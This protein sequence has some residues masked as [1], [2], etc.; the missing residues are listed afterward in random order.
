MWFN[1]SQG[2][3]IMK[4]NIETLKT[5]RDI[6]MNIKLLYEIYNYNIRLKAIE[7]LDYQINE[8]FNLYCSDS[9]ENKK[10]K[11]KVLTLGSNHLL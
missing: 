9:Q 6:I 2:G 5:Y 8:I 1:I 7:Y 4:K 11:V 10:E 3:N